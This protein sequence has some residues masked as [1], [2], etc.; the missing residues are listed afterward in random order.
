MGRVNYGTHLED[1]KGLVGDIEV[2]YPEADWCRKKHFGYDIYALPL[3]TLPKEY[4][5]EACE[6]TPA[7]YRYTFTAD[8]LHDTVLNLDGFT[9]GVAFVN[10]FNLG[11][12]WTVEHSPNKLFIPAPLLKKGVNEIVVFDVLA[13]GNEKNLIFGE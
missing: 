6:N 7:F 2:I 1:R 9:R 10:G 8:E 11:R 3:E 4:K 5:D 12:H 13:N